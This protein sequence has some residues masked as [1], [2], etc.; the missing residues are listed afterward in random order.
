MPFFKK[1]PVV[2]EAHRFSGSSTDAACFRK[3][4]E[5]GEYRRSSIQTCDIRDLEIHTLEG[6]MKA[7][8]G[9]YVIKGVNG[10]FYPCKPEIFAAT[11]EAVEQ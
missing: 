7:R 4:F 6:V 10:E 11:Y 8:P 3:W 2:I 5:G 1:K 9:D